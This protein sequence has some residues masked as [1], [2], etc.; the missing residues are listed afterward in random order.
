LAERLGWV[1]IPVGDV[2]RG[3]AC[4]WDIRHVDRL[5]PKFSQLFVCVSPGGAS[6]VDA[7]GLWTPGGAREEERRGTRE[8]GQAESAGG[9]RWMGQPPPGDFFAC[10]PGPRG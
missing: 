6:A 7:G 1:V 8:S 10:A 4:E 9:E 2:G 3:G 5:A